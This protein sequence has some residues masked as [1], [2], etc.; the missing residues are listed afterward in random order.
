M[1]DEIVVFDYIY[2]VLH[3]PAYRESYA[4]FLKIDFPRI[5]WPSSPDEFWDLSTKAVNSSL[6]EAR[7]PGLDASCAFLACASDI[8]VAL[9]TQV[10]P[11]HFMPTAQRCHTSL[12]WV[13]V[14]SWPSADRV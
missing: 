10:L 8:L 6:L 14:T 12:V 7:Q 2:G 4:E 9:P 11:S 13:S 5:P 1:P 3:C